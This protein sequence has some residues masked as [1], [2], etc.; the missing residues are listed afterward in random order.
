MESNYTLEEF[1]AEIVRREHSKYDFVAPTPQMSMLDD[2][3]TIDLGAKGQY[4]AQSNFHS[5]VANHLK[6]PKKYYDNMA[7]IPGLR[8]HNVNQW[9]HHNPEERMIRTLDGHARA[10]LSAKF[11]PLDNAFTL[12]AVNP[13]FDDFQGLQVKSQALTDNRMYLQVVFPSLEADIG[14]GDTVQQG[15]IITNSEV[16]R[17]ALDVSSLIWRLQCLNGMVGQSILSKRHV[18]SRIDFNTEDV[19]VYQHD[20]IEAELE[21]YRLRVRDV[22]R[23]AL[24]ESVFAERID[25]IRRANEDDIPTKKVKRTI[26]NVTKKLAFSEDDIDGIFANISKEGNHTRWGLANAITALAH[27]TENPDK[28]Y[29]YERAGNTIITL[30]PNEWSQMVA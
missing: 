27:D 6:I 3:N 1:K 22:V 24:T 16:G 2:D 23:H 14:V 12:K 15:I 20:T 30:S 13:V 4:D 28:G 29:D 10:F 9:L 17:G 25:E 11:R 5:Q 18:G 21:S 26:E 19:N 8:S 7:A